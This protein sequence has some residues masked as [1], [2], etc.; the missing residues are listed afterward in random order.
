MISPRVGL[1]LVALS[2]TA[3]AGCNNGG[4]GR[5]SDAASA[6]AA[7][8]TAST[9]AAVTT[10]VLTVTSGSASP[11]A[12]VPG[13]TAH[14]FA[15]PAPADQVFEGWSGDTTV[16]ADPLAWHTTLVMP[17]RGVN[18]VA[19]Y[20]PSAPWT[21][22]VEVMGVDPAAREPIQL[23][24]H[25]P[26]NPLGLAFF[27]HGLGGKA[28]QAFE[29]SEALTLTR[30]LIANGFAVAAL[31]CSDRTTREWNS[32]RSSTNPDV[33][34]TRRAIAR[35]ESLGVIGPATSLYSIGV[36][37]GG[38]FAA[39]PALHIAGR[40]KAVSIHCASGSPDD[41]F[42]D[43]THGYV[44]PT[45][46]SL[47]EQ[48]WRAFTPQATANRDAL[49]ARGVGT[50]LV[51]NAPSPV[52]PRRFLRVPGLTEA[53]SRAIHDALAANGKLDAADFLL[54]SPQ[55]DTTLAGLLPAQLRGYGSDIVTQLNCSYS[56][57]EL[58]SEPAHL[59]VAFFRRFP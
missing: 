3:A 36:S 43:A 10:P 35:L 57:H 52:F 34:L 11:A 18:L 31:D 38:G 14:V 25:S 37:R 1:A 32:S 46:W 21:P 27:F 42:S 28:A 33:E 17:A 50:E 16:L 53:D 39:K 45:R 15:D 44:V 22:A 24:Y 19:R 9:T 30:V 20:V 4:G 8:G 13:A 26:P 48:D 41:W 7:P 12:P 2:L 23:V 6:V 59:L 55:T 56:E 51:V 54:A 49:L 58:F 5:S 29:K 40:F 47:A